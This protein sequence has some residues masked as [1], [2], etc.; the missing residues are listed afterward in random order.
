MTTTYPRAA[1][2]PPPEAAARPAA[3]RGTL[4]VRTPVIEHTIERM[5][6]DV[7][8]VVRRRGS[9]TG[10]GSGY[11]RASVRIDGTWA[12]AQV[13]VAAVWP[14]RVA[15]VAAEVRTLVIDAVEPLVGVQLRRAD[16]TVHVVPPSA[17][18]LPRRVS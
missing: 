16:V 2:P 18:E 3:E 12:S 9:R 15:D 13:D 4:E 11:P 17:D 7:A 8:T 1:V 10:L 6:L 5:V 14:T